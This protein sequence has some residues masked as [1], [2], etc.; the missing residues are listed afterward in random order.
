MTEF[1]QLAVQGLALGSIYALIALGFVIIYKATEVINFSH[2]ALMLLGA[3]LTFTLTSA[4]LPNPAGGPVGFP[5]WLDWWVE[6]GIEWRF[7]IAVV[8]AALL[9]AVLGLLIERSV[10]RKMIGQPVFA[11]VLITLGLE[12]VIRTGV[13]IFWGP[14][15]RGFPSPFPITSRVRIGSVAILTA[16]LWTII[17]TFFLV[18]GFFVF[19][20]YTRYGLAM[21]AT[22]LDQEAARSMGIK[23]S[24]VFA[25][26]WAIAGAL[27]AIAGALYVPA[28]LGGFLVITP[29]AFSAL[30]AFP[31]AILGG[32][33][34]PGGA[35]LG[36]IVVGE[37]E[38]LASRYINPYLLDLGLP[39]FHLIFGYVLLVAVLLIRPY[40]LF[41][42]R[43]VRRV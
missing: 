33:D 31:A 40:G 12:V 6:L 21:R 28:R 36:G 43:E 19:F 11:I 20:R 4:Q 35:V 18:F 23:A 32:L 22:A 42:T 9:V 15:Q 29:V 25:L 26:A 5:S 8:V 37:A 38:V 16:N 39:N 34:S 30:R 13:Q 7:P 10:I 2:G 1:L 17:I 27:A 24:T 14:V 41:G 3:Y